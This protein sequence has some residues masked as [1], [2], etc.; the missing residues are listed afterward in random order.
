MAAMQEGSTELELRAFQM[1]I[2][3]EISSLRKTGVTGEEGGARPETIVGVIL[4]RLRSR[5]VQHLRKSKG[6]SRSNNGM[7]CVCFICIKHIPM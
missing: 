6:N 3:G 5:K 4:F 2:T 1:W 7:C